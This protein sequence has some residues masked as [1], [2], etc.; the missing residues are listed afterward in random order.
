VGRG[1]KA[2]DTSDTAVHADA[3]QG[4]TQ[5]ASQQIKAVLG[6][7]AVEIA[8]LPTLTTATL[9]TCARTAGANIS[10][11]QEVEVSQCFDGIVESTKA[12]PLDGAALDDA[13]VEEEEGDGQL[14]FAPLTAAPEELDEFIA[15]N[16]D[17]E[18]KRAIAQQLL[19]HQDR[20]IPVVPSVPLP[21]RWA[22]FTFGLVHY[23]NKMT[24]EVQWEPPAANEANHSNPTSGANQALVNTPI[25]FAPILDDWTMEAEEGGASWLYSGRGYGEYGLRPGLSRNFSVPAW[26]RDHSVSLIMSETGRVYRLGQPA[27][28]SQPG[29]A[30]RRREDV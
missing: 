30:K 15:K 18:R 4:G 16:A 8:P 3:S 20:R 12:V 22:A 10:P 27:A 19:Q 7:P 11:E 14:P 9:L 21:P 1:H 24:S 28:V 23:H 13:M 17:V 6:R 26:S 25:S 29:E 2:A 5:P